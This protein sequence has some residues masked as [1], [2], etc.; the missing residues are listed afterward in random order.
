MYTI[1]EHLLFHLKSKHREY[2]PSELQVVEKQVLKELTSRQMI[3]P[4]AQ[5]NYPITAIQLQVFELDSCNWIP[6]T[7]LQLRSK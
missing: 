5:R 1:R 6:T 7:A 3:D 2:T 4:R